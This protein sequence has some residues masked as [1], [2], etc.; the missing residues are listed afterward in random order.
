MEPKFGIWPCPQG[1]SDPVW[2]HNGL[3]NDAKES[4]PIANYHVEGAACSA[5]E[6]FQ[7]RGSHCRQKRLEK[8]AGKPGKVGGLQGAVYLRF[9]P[10]AAPLPCLVFAIALGII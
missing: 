7:V 5:L 8:A 6:S 3:R 1:T 9:V 2:K 4:V 10:C